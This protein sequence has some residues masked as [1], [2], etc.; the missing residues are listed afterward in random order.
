M[1][2]FISDA[3]IE[4]IALGVI[5]RTLPKPEWTHAAHFAAALWVLRRP[6]MNAEAEMPRLIR[7][8]NRATGVENTDSSGYHET[9]TLASLRAARD[10]LEKRPEKPLHEVLNEL[11]ASRYGRSDWLLEHWSK[12]VLFS[13]M[14]RRAWIDPDL[15]PLPF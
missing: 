10:W 11:L 2:H 6:G 9:I 15:E 4:R 12:A 3:E 5:E 14:A 7:A 13:V 8:Y 1:I